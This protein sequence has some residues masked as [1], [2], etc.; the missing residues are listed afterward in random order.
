MH[1]FASRCIEFDL[2]SFWPFFKRVYVCLQWLCIVFWRDLFVYFCVI[3]QQCCY[4][5]YYIGEIIYENKKQKGQVRFLG[6]C[7]FLRLSTVSKN[8]P[9]EPVVYAHLGSYWSIHKCSPLLHKRL[10]LALVVGAEQRHIFL[11][12][13][14]KC[15]QCIPPV[16]IAVHSSITPSN[17]VT[18]DLFDLKPCWFSTSK[19]FLSMCMTI[20]SLI[21][22]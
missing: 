20:L 11:R 22:D 3:S 10:V 17:C 12:N 1:A 13:Q 6:E 21:K 5:A 4:V 15:N 7:R 18:H 8:F 9:T 14:D 16:K 19:I 2:P